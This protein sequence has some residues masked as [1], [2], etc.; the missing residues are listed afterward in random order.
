[1]YLT[2][3]PTV[4]NTQSATPF[5]PPVNPGV[6]LVIT[7]A[8]PTAAQI[9][10]AHRQHNSKA[11]IFK[12]YD[13]TDKALK[14]LIMSVVDETYLR[15]LRDRHVGYANL[16]TLQILRHLYNNCAKVTPYDLEQND[17]QMKTQWDP[18]EPFETLIDQSMDGMEFSAA[19][20]NAYTPQQ[21]VTI[22][23]NLVAN[24]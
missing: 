3:T 19:G 7:Q 10:K 24:T 4:Y 5:V 15:A 12:E 8:M 23:Y 13:D 16:T 22:S 1:M 21:V 6:A 9:T 14:A 20:N 11:A 17:K 18:N 2:V